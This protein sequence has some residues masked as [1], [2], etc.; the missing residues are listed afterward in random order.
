MNKNEGEKAP[1]ISIAETSERTMIQMHKDQKD[2]ML[3]NSTHSLHRSRTE[4]ISKSLG[5]K[6][7]HRSYDTPTWLRMLATVIAILI[8][9]G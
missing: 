6:I 5:K 7:T 4:Q 8:V 3:A 9:P 2:P 1:L